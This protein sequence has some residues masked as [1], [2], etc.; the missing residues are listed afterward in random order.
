MYKVNDH[1]QYTIFDFN[2]PVGLHMNPNNR[3]IQMADRIP[4]DEFE[5]RY[6]KLFKSKTGNVAKPLRMAL[7][8]MIIQ[9]KYQFSDRELVAQLTE[10]PYFQYFIGLP[11]YK[12]EAPFDPSLM[13]TFRKRISSDML[14]EINS[15]ILD[16]DDDKK[17]PPASSGSGKEDLD[18]TD[19]SEKKQGH[20]DVRCDLCTCKHQISAGCI[21]IE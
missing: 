11:G 19:D 5:I 3:W 7:G 10:N 15:Y 18:K 1:Q 2:Q 20:A 9:T 8:A 14:M 4:W 6:K 21:T 17:D 13:V 12:E 16:Q